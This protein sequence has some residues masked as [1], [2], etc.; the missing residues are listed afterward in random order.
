MGLNFQ[1]CTIINSTDRFSKTGE[2]LFVKNDFLFE[3]GKVKSIYKKEGYNW[4]EATVTVDIPTAPGNYRL[5]VF[6]KY[7]GAEPAYAANAVNTYKGVPFW[8]EFSGGTT[9]TATA[10]ANQI[11]KDSLFLI[12]K[13]INHIIVILLY[14]SKQYY[15]IIPC[16]S[17]KCNYNKCCFAGCQF[18]SKEYVCG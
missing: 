11:K 12:N 13:N 4:K 16:H 8:V 3:K 1:T 7:D 18:N 15:N 6:V 5:D 14:I 17:I 10:I 2:K 9:A